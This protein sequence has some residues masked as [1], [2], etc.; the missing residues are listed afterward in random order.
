MAARKSRDVWTPQVVRDRIRV[1][2][3]VNR[4]HACA[5]GEIELTPSQL[6]SIEILLKK[7]VPDLRSIEHT[8]HIQHTHASQLTDEQLAHIAAGGSAGVVDATTSEEGSTP[9]H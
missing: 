3:L 9:V 6:K 8:G 5:A 1:A 2:M 7:A 4:L